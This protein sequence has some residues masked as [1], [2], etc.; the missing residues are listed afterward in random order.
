MENHVVLTA[1]IAEAQ[2]LRYTPAGLPALDLKL[3]HGSQQQEA[4]AQREVKAVVKA[5]AFGTLAER[6]ARQA[7][8]S[9]WIFRGFL[10]TSRNG[11]GLVFHIQDIQQD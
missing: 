2:A 7:L 4:G 11:K 3:E 8:G 9:L 5:I 6:L 1:C 10:A